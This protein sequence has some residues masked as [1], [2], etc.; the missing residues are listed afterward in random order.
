M[1]KTSKYFIFILMLIECK[2]LYDPRV[3]SHNIPQHRTI[4]YAPPEKQ[5]KELCSSQVN[6]ITPAFVQHYGFSVLPLKDLVNHPLILVGL[7]RKCTSLLGFIILCVQVWE[8]TGYDGDIVFLMVPDESEFGCRVPLVIGTCKIDQ[9]INIIWESE[10]DRLSMSWATARMVQLLTCQKSTAVLT[11]GSVGEAKSEGTNRGPQEVD[12]DELVTVR[13][14]LLRTISDRNHKGM[15][16]TPLW[17]YGPH[18]DHTAEGGRRSTAGSQA[19]SSRTPCPP[20]I[21]MPQKQQWQ[22]F[23]HG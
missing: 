1:Y 2:T 17:R 7:G 19:S 23:T 16:Q 6:T 11:P 4:H 15:S 20:C 21:H 13:E 9:I 10:I 12:V 14:C 5:A 18:D 22:G 3:H 8:I